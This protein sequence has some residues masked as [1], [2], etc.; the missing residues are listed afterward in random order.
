MEF[1]TF[2]E[3]GNFGMYPESHWSGKTMK[4][5]GPHSEC[6]PTAFVLVCFCVCE[7]DLGAVAIDE[8]CVCVCMHACLNVCVCAHA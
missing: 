5:V 8:Q 3:T 6:E 2:V 4:D 1:C 7:T